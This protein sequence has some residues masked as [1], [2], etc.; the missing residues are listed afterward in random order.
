[1]AY[2]PRVELCEVG[3]RDGFQF[4]QK[5]IPTELKRAVIEQLVAA[6]VSRIQV[7]S[8]VHPKWVPQMADAEALV[9]RLPERPGVVY[10]GLVLN[11]RGLERALRTRLSHVDLS[12]A[13]NEQHSRDN[14]NMTVDEGLEAAVAMVQTARRHGVAVQLGL[15]TV[16]GYAAPGDTPLDRVLAMARRFRDLG[17]ES[18]SLADSTGLANPVMIRER[19][20]AVQ[21]VMGDVPIVL[22]L[23]DTRG[24]GLANV[25]AALE[26]GVS[27][28]DTSLGGL[29]GCPFIPGATGNIATEDTVYLLDQL[30]IETGIDLAGVAAVSRRMAAF[31][32]RELP[33]KLYRLVTN[34]AAS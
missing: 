29:G 14:A 28:F 22:H 12:I 1:M 17:I 26:I 11:P 13:T 9:A 16:F 21:A 32:G 19:V 23:H 24:L 30:G 10:S 31:L 33:G 20:Q 6:G 5:P 25:V 2:P 27:R 7:T 3:P 34:E 8:F 18:L 15:Q 4:E